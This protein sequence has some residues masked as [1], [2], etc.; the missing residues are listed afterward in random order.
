MSNLRTRNRLP[1]NFIDG[2]AIQGIDVTHLKD[3]SSPT[4]ST[5]VGHNASTVKA[6][7]D[8][9]YTT[10]QGLIQSINIL[11]N[12]Y[13]TLNGEAVKI[14]GNQTIAGTKTF[15][16]TIVGSINGNSATAT[17]LATPRTISGVAFDGT[18]NIDLQGASTET[19]GI[20]RI[21]NLLQAQTGTNNEVVMTPATV[22]HHMTA[23]ALGW[24]QTWVNLTG[25]RAVNWEYQN[26]TGR[27]ILVTITGRSYGAKVF[28]VKSEIEGATYE[29]IAFFNSVGEP[30]SS[31]TVIVP[32]GS[33]YRF[34]GDSGEIY[35][36]AELR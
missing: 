1:H 26:L 4:G 27:P 33:Y 11:S 19:S 34:N 23:N 30:H 36:W 2:I 32:A 10:A 17:K 28:E 14:T 13:N 35:S 22:E 18:A 25:S 6:E 15:S 12:V 16:S 31:V 29:A 21:A 24:G 3:I 7:I 20:V 8:N 5:L 9:L